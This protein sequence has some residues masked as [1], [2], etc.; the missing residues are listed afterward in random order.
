MCVCV[1][2]CFCTVGQ[3]SLFLELVG[4]GQVGENGGGGH[5]ANGQSSCGKECVLCLFF[6]GLVFNLHLGFESPNVGLSV[7]VDRN[8]TLNKGTGRSG[9]SRKGRVDLFFRGGVGVQQDSLARQNSLVGRDYTCVCVCVST[10]KKETT[11]TFHT[12]RKGRNNSPEKALTEAT[13]RKRIARNRAMMYYSKDKKEC[14]IAIKRE[15]RGE[16]DDTAGQ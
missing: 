1:F 4:I 5:D 3:L 2:G 11:T 7:L 8:T 16:R 10:T 9:R 15:T 12:M 6:V 14:V 13:K